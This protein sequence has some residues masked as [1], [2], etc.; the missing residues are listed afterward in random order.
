MQRPKG[1]REFSWS[2]NQ[3]R[4]VPDARVD[5]QEALCA[6]ETDVGKNRRTGWSGVCSHSKD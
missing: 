2:K 4:S 5:Q 3:V 1:V 6:E